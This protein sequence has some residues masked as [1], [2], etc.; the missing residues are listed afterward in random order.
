MI[1]MGGNNGN[2]CAGWFVWNRRGTNYK[3]NNFPH[4]VDRRGYTPQR[5]HGRSE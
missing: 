2:S 3:A 1:G 5:E 4:E